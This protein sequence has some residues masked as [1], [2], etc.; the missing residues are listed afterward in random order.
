[1]KQKEIN[2]LSD[3]ELRERINDMRRSFSQ[4]KLHDAVNKLENPMK[5]RHTRRTIARLL[6]E[7]KKRQAA[8]NSN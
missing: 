4:M 7:Q 8:K 6:T 1:M 5:I 3:Q 2:E